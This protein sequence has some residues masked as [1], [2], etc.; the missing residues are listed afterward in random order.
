M[1]G[2][3]DEYYQP[4]TAATTPRKRSRTGVRGQKTDHQVYHKSSTLFLPGFWLYGRTFLTSSVWDA[5]ASGRHPG[6]PSCKRHYIHSECNAN[7]R[8]QR[9]WSFLSVFDKKKFDNLWNN[10]FNLR[11][12]QQNH[13]ILKKNN[14]LRYFSS[15]HHSKYSKWFRFDAKVHR[16]ILDI[17]F[18]RGPFNVTITRPHFGFDSWSIPDCFEIVLLTVL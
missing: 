1:V 5:Q 16:E 2:T 7:L 10:D 13:K 17:S 8:F 15:V 12:V 6:V 18:C 3:S 14:L 9:C 4:G 11:N